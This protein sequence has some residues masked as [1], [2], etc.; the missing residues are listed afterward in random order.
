MV[1]IEVSEEV[2]GVAWGACTELESQAFS[3]QV[4]RLVP[5]AQCLE[6]YLDHFLENNIIIVRNFPALRLR[7]LGTGVR[8]EFDCQPDMFDQLSLWAFHN[9]TESLEVPFGENEVF[10]ML[11]LEKSFAILDIQQHWCQSDRYRKQLL[12]WPGGL[13]KETIPKTLHLVWE[14]MEL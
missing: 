12:E 11:W 3:V 4:G 8:Y 2:L 13:L 1:K 7:T 6:E 10:E 9:A 14:P 5:R